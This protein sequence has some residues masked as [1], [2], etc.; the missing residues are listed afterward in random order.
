MDEKGERLAVPGPQGERGK[1]GTAVLSSP[2]RRSLVFL[3]ALSVLLGGANLLW[4]AHEVHA[5]RAA[6]QAS[7]VHE[8]AM[9]QQ[10]RRAIL[11]ALCMTFTELAVLKP[12]AGDPRT[13]PS[14][15]FEQAE[16][17]T[18]DEIGGDLGCKR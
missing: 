4:T 1:P 13:N 14:R 9:Q 18:L 8:Q 12:P 17:A 5:S 3:F 16:H 7:Q 15:A 6:I 2:V 11:R 10:D